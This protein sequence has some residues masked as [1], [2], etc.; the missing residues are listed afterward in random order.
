MR[1]SIVSR[2]DVSGVMVTTFAGLI[3]PQECAALIE[4][5][6]GCEKPASVCDTQ[7]GEVKKDDVRTNR[8][9]WVDPQHPLVDAI[10]RRIAAL[11]GIPLENQEP[12]QVLHYLPG[13]RYVPHLDA[14]QPGSKHLEHGGNR[15][16]TVLLYLNEVE[17]GGGT[18]FP[19]LGLTVYPHTGLGVFFRSIDAQG[20]I[21]PKSLH[22]GDTVTAGEKWVASKWIRERAYV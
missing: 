12:L 21:L 1:I 3:H 9:S 13:E 5:G 6:K 10:N 11:T 17:G 22:T 19:E 2:A 15:Q 8:M 4:L 7:T 20:G 18:S 14:F 16:A